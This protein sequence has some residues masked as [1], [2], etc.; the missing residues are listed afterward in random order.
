MS[1]L[2][3]DHFTFIITKINKFLLGTAFKIAEQIRMF[4]ENLAKFGTAHGA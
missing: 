1:A 4:Q 2:I 3:Q